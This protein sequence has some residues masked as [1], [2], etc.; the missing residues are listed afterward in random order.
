M[1]LHEDG[2]VIM[3]QTT[4]QAPLVPKEIANVLEQET[5]GCAEASKLGRPLIL[6]S[7]NTFWRFW[8]TQSNIFFFQH[9]ESSVTKIEAQMNQKPKAELLGSKVL[10]FFRV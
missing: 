9:A 1:I 10:Q 8:S 3:G 6:Q 7:R 5:F 4:S 2:I